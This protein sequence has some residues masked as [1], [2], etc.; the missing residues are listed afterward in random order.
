MPD[1]SQDLTAS[2][3]PYRKKDVAIPA[4]LN[5]LLPELASI[6]IVLS[7]VYSLKI[8]KDSLVRGIKSADN[9]AKEI[10]R[11]LRD[12]LNDAAGKDVQLASLNKEV[13]SLK[14]K[15]AAMKEDQ[16]EKLA[17]AEKRGAASAEV[18][19]CPE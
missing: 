15:V 16:D 7:A 17:V 13:S 2:A 4:M 1:L 3:V 8:S 9:E 10:A 14:T 12:A 11:A 19:R 5:P 18:R 6:L